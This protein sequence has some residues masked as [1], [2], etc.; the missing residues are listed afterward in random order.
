MKYGIIFAAAIGPIP[1]CIG[2]DAPTAPLPASTLV[3]DPRAVQDVVF[4]SDSRPVFFRCHIYIDGQPFQALWDD[5]MCHLFEYLDR[6]GDGILSKEEGERAPSAQQLLDILQGGGS[7]IRAAGT[8]SIFQEMDTD[9]VDGVVTLKKLRAYYRRNGQ[10]ALVLASTQ[11]AGYPS[12]MLTDALFHYLDVN[13]DG[14]LSREE[15]QAALVRLRHLDLDEDET[16]SAKELVLGLTGNQP[17]PVGS[18][19]GSPGIAGLGFGSS[20]FF[21]AGP[22]KPHRNLHNFC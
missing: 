22:D 12:G 15:L 2:A 20:E 18:S 4:L 8:P 7:P 6:D 21:L 3:R 17:K 16:I 9:P 10:G 19:V 11:R 1:V 13:R 14:K 5:Y